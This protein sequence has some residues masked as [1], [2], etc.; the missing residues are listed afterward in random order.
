MTIQYTNKVPEMQQ[1]ENDKMKQELAL[2]NYHRLVQ[3]LGRM[4][5]VLGA[6]LGLVYTLGG[7][8]MIWNY[9]N[10]PLGMVILVAIELSG[11]AFGGALVA[12]IGVLERKRWAVRLGKVVYFSLFWLLMTVWGL[13]FMG[14]DEGYDMGFPETYSILIALSAFP[15][16]WGVIG[17][18]LVLYHKLAPQYFQGGF[19]FEPL[20]WE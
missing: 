12:S 20:D 16:F 15:A 1:M 11:I 8:Y 18:L 3:W 5:F 6:L 9:W 17:A 2:A 19:R 10:E 14:Y 7:A 4:G 13:S